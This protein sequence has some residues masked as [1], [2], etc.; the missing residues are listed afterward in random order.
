MPEYLAAQYYAQHFFFTHMQERAE[1]HTYPQLARNSY[2][3]A[4][5]C[6]CLVDFFSV[7][8]FAHEQTPMAWFVRLVIRIYL[9]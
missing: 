2:L 3:M 6:R 9:R 8:I 4:F 7:Y 5:H 1:M